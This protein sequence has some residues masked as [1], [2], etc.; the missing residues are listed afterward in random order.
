[1]RDPAASGL[2]IGEVSRRTG[3]PVTTLRFYERELPGL[4]PIRKTAGGHR[5]YDA[6]DV[7]RFSSVRSLTGEGLALS[8]LRRILMS[9][10]DHEAL[11]EAVDLLGQAQETGARAVERLA[12]RLDSLEVRLSEL[13]NRPARR[14]WFGRRPGRPGSE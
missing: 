10:G 4:F 11:R 14:G 12:R 9:R 7:S 8:E 2:S 1:M 3:I 13:E 5:R 6:R